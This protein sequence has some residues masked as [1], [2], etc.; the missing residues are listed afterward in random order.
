MISFPEMLLTCLPVPKVQPGERGKRDDD[1]GREREQKKERKRERKSLNEIEMSFFSKE[2]RNENVMKGSVEIRDQ[3][4]EKILLLT[5]SLTF[6]FF[7]FLLFSVLPPVSLVGK[8][9]TSEIDGQ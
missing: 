6:S 2:K 7:L 3:G 5:H 8:R 1:H 9:R 4:R